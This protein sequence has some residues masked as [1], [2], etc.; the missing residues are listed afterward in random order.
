TVEEETKSS[1]LG[2]VKGEALEEAERQRKTVGVNRGLK[3]ATGEMVC[4]SD[5]ECEW[6]KDALRN[7]VKYFSDP[8]IGSVSGIHETRLD[9]KALSVKVEDSYRSIYRMLRIADSKVH[10]TL[11]SEG[12]IELYRWG[13]FVVFDSRISGD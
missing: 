9:R 1:K 5:A 8:M 7:A 10:S 11:V 3:Q 6:D 2:D 4:F 12:E 13:H